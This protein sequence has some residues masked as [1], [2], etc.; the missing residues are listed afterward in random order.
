MNHA[1]HN[2]DEML[3]DNPSVDP[4]QFEEVVKVLKE[5]S[6][7]GVA[8]ETGYSLPLPFSK[9]MTRRDEEACRERTVR[10]HTRR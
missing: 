3:R 1:K 5:L 2:I 8:T 6:E 10:L 7:T 9:Q 4:K